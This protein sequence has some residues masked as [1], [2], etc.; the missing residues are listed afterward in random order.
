MDTMSIPQLAKAVPDEDAAYRFL[1]DLRWGDRPVCPH[2]GSLR[3]HY[4]LAPKNAEGRKTRTGAI[5]HRRLWKCADCRRQ[6][7]VLTGTMMHR[8]KIPVRTWVFVVFEM[9]ASKNGVA[10]REIERKYGLTPRSAW[11]MT[12]RIREA[13]KRDA[14]APLF[15][16]T[17]EAD[18]T[19]IGPKSKGTQRKSGKQGWRA[20][21]TPVVTVVERESGEARSRVVHRVTAETLGATLAANVAPEAVLMTDGL[22]AYR[23]IAPAYAEHHRVRH[24]IGEYARTTANGRRAHSNTVEGFFSQLKRSIDGTHHFVTVEHL[25]RYL[26][27]FDFR[28]STRKYTDG[29][30]VSRLMGRAPGRA[31]TYDRLTG[32]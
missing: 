10:A 18:E 29:Q 25:D 12:Q 4:F 8:S 23:K 5:T 31:L 20:D 26:A 14:D 27:E 17:V 28:Y 15:T 21:K 2:C 22:Q 9:C 24:D 11:F 1:E 3:K 30:R 19:Y 32:R 16:G 7:S 6:F 13:M